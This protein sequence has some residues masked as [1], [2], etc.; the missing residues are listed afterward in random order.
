MFIRHLVLIILKQV[1]SLKLQGHMSQNE[2]C[3]LQTC[4]KISIKIYIFKL[5]TCFGI[6]STKCRINTAVSPDDGHMVTR[7]V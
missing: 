1:D 6:A 2:E 3:Y 7:N 4:D 5:S